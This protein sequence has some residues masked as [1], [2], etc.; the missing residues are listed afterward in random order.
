MLAH[1]AVL[2]SE[3]GNL[4]VKPDAFASDSGRG[5]A[6]WGAANLLVG[7]AGLVAIVPLFGYFVRFPW[8]LF[9]T[10]AP[11]PWDT[12]SYHL[13][14]FVEFFQERS[15]WSMKGPYQSFG[16]GF[17][18]IG[19]YP[20]YFFQSHWGLL[21]AHGYAL[22]FLSASIWLMVRQLIRT[23][24]L[25]REIH[26]LSAFL[27]SM[28]FWVLLFRAEILNVGKNDIF[29]T[30]CIMSAFALLLEVLAKEPH[31]LRSPEVRAH[32][33]FATFAYA[34]ALASKP[35]ALAY[36]P[37]FGVMPLATGWQARGR[38]RDTGSA[39]ALAVA[40]SLGAVLIGGFFLI[41]N[42]ILL[43]SI[44]DP[45]LAQTWQMSIGANLGNA[46][47]YKFRWAGVYFLVTL[48]TPVV[49]AL[50]WRFRVRPGSVISYACTT[51]LSL[52]SLLAFVVTPFGAF[53]G[54]PSEPRW[55]IR[56]GMPLFVISAA[57]LSVLLAL[58][59]HRI[60]WRLAADTL[61]G[62]VG[63]LAAA[64]VTGVA[65]IAVPRYWDVH[66][67]EGLPGY[68]VTMD[69]A[70]TSIYEWVDSIRAP[71]RIYAI[72]LRPYG[73]YGRHWQHRVFYDLNATALQ[74]DDTGKARLRQV[75]RQFRP[76][77]VVLSVDPIGYRP[78]APIPLAGWVRAKP[79][80]FEEVYAE[81]TVAVFRVR[82]RIYEALG[83]DS[84]S[85]PPLRM[86]S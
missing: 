44:A 40:F 63:V 67:A 9:R 25:S 15:L 21:F 77:L 36:F 74:R 69:V 80:W 46:S 58:F 32:L 3:A 86:G 73:L 65:L 71:V 27:L 24:G 42:L 39:V 7:A 56:L 75:L 35:T 28:G 49:L 45:T 37:L 61:R 19:N 54:D 76:D 51:G 17:E 48:T 84:S 57:A 8:E 16:F 72:G 26:V 85:S 66:R 33:V 38:T 1:I 12:V 79:E 10:D 22:V 60:P 18:L 59:L 52:V 53:H 43:G 14:G 23:M 83:K 64:L 11:L 55:D 82:D 2:A 13:P 20:S 41:R 78:S 62:R 4:P 68:E 6:P 34:L 5:N 70:P 30:A 81:P 31:R 50:L 47:L 29:V